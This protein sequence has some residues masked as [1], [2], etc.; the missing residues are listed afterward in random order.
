MAAQVPPVRLMSVKANVNGG[1]KTTIR[2]EAG[3]KAA[4]D[5]LRDVVRGFLSLARLQ[6][7]SKPELEK[8]LKTIE[9]SGTDATVLLSFAV[10][11]ETLSVITP[12]PRRRGG[13]PGEPVTPNPAPGK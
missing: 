2:A 5:Q 7:G 1:I 8:V 12:G 6:A 13:E 11:P 10:S 9:L 4:A 3:D